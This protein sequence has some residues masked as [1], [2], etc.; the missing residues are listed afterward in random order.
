MILR[1]I[2]LLLY[3]DSLLRKWYQSADQIY[4]VIT[5]KLTRGIYETGFQMLWGKAI[6]R[7]VILLQSS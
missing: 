2:F 5:I 6:E 4:V 3:C 7:I 1:I